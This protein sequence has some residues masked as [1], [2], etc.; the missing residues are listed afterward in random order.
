MTLDEFLK[1]IADKQP[2]IGVFEKW[3]ALVGGMLERCV[4]QI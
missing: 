2:P 4:S 3:K 1:S